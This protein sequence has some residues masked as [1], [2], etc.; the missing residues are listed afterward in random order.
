MKKAEFIKAVAEKSGATQKVADAVVAAALDTIREAL[1]GGDSVTFLQFGSFKVSQR[2]ARMGRNPQDGKE[3]KI[4]AAKIPVFK[5]SAAF[6]ELVNEKKTRK[7][8][9]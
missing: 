3:I 2:K 6:K 1:K 7:A 5:A 8:K 9:K 4:P